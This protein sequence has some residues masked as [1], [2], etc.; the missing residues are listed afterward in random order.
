MAF[1]PFAPCMAHGRGP[2]IKKACLMSSLPLSIPADALV[3]F[4]A[5]LAYQE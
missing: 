3:A 2:I 4:S 1:R 5:P